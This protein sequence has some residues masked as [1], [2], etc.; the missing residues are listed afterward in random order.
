MS[1]VLMSEDC[2]YLNVFVRAD[3]W[4]NKNITKTPILVFIHGGAYVSGT[5]SSDL[6]E[7]ST[8]VSMKGI[9]VVTLNYRLDAFGFLHIQGTDSTGNQVIIINYY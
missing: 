9:I 7:P 5:A 2:L 6:Y 3:T 4:L 1:A 8:I